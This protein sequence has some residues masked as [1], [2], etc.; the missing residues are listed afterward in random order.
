MPWR[1]D[2]SLVTGNFVCESAS[3]ALR[4]E[5][6]KS[7]T[8]F[9]FASELQ[10]SVLGNPSKGKKGHALAVKELGRGIEIGNKRNIFHSYNRRNRIQRVLIHQM[11]T[12]LDRLSSAALKQS[13]LKMTTSNTILSRIIPRGQWGGVGT[14]CGIASAYMSS[15]AKPYTGMDYVG[16][17]GKRFLRQVKVHPG[18]IPWKKYLKPGD[19]LFHSEIGKTY[20]IRWV[21]CNDTSCFLDNAI[22][23]GNEGLLFKEVSPLELRLYLP[24]PVKN[25]PSV[26]AWYGLLGIGGGQ[27]VL[28]IPKGK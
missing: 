19:V 25:V 12:A 6:I 10:G 7:A 11:R 16:V 3:S 4:Y 5:A 26:I 20:D 21:E 13:A 23:F 17:G 24:D 22:V 28:Y 2:Y 18:V 27:N 1:W 9:Q 15:Y 14:R 8:I